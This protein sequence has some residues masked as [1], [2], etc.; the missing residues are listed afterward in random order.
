MASGVSS[1]VRL[2]EAAEFGSWFVLGL[3][4]LVCRFW[5]LVLS[6]LA[7]AVSGSGSDLALSVAQ[8]AGPT[9]G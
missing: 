3:S 2:I 1:F 6:I 4:I 8:P 5:F 7:S 9:G